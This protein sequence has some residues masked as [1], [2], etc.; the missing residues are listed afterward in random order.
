MLRKHKT[1]FVYIKKRFNFSLALK[2]GMSL[3]KLSHYEREQKVKIFGKK[4]KGSYKSTHI[5][6]KFWLDWQL[7]RRAVAATVGTPAPQ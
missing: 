2:V 1:K 6:A 5:A 7:Q 3:M 4:V